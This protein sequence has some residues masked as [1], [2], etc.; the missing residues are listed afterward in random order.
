MNDD[1]FSEHLNNP[2]SLKEIL[3]DPIMLAMLDPLPF[4]TYVKNATTEILNSKVTELNMIKLS[5]LLHSLRVF[6]DLLVK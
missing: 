3:F 2:K 5:W 6:C 4:F 1:P